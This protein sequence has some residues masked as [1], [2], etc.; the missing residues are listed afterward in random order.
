MATKTVILTKPRVAFLLLLAIAISVLFFWV[1]ENFVLPVFL[2]AVLSGM[3]QPIYRRTLKWTGGRQSLASALTVGLSFVAGIIPLLLLLG[4]ISS[5][6]IQISKSAT[7][8][9]DAQGQDSVALQER[10]AADPYLKRLLPYQNQIVEKLS[11]FAAMAG[12]W[13]ALRLAGGVKGTAAF[14]LSLFVMIY[15][16]YYFLPHLRAILDK[17]LQYTPLTSDD[18]SR[19]LGTFVSVARATMKGKLIVGIVQGGLAGLSFWVAGIEGV[20]FW[21]A[22][23]A[24]LSAIPSIGTA[25]VWIP[26]VAFLALNGQAGAAVGVALWCA[27]VVG[28]VDNVLTPKLIGKDIEMPDLLVLLTT[29]GGLASFGA[30]GIVIGPIIGALFIAT[31]QLW[32]SAFNEARRTNDET[33]E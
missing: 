2:A 10:L 17:A 5:Q 20:L 33:A 25:L 6:A 31:W 21:S 12:G 32:G 7:D 27:L 28:T 26:A 29:L 14:F 3:L 13:I 16:T 4:L 18:R 19:L 23:M 30:A 8:W 24:V 9:L 15:A 22:V 1:I 11:E